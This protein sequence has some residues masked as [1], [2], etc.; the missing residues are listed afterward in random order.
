[1]CDARADGLSVPRM[2]GATAA[3]ATTAAATT[4]R[5]RAIVDAFAAGDGAKAVAEERRSS[6]GVD[7]ESNSGGS[8]CSTH[9]R[10]SESLTLD[11]LSKDERALV[12]ERCR[13][14]GLGSRSEGDDASGTR[15]VTIFRRRDV[16]ATTTTTTKT[17]K[18]KTTTMPAA[19]AVAEDDDDDDD[20]A[21]VSAHDDSLMDLRDAPFDVY[22][23]LKIPRRDGGGYGGGNARARASYHREISR[24]HPRDFPPGRGSCHGCGGVLK[25]GRWFHRPS[26]CAAAEEGADGGGVEEDGRVAVARSLRC[27]LYNAGP[28]AT[29]SAR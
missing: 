20:D 28:H 14:L 4:A 25:P 21:R 27:V 11:E 9:S 7:A 22:R 29:A 24:C 17:T 23:A 10:D 1:L 6:A 19:R 12:H 15:V 13:A 8:N 5:W 3:A 2:D 16:A 18:T 26:P